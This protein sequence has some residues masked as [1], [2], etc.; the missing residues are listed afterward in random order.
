MSE[1]TELLRSKKG[2]DNS[3]NAGDSI[4]A[5]DWST[6]QQHLPLVAY[7]QSL[8]RM[9]REHPAFRMTTAE[10]ISRYL[11]FE[12]APPGCIAY[13]LNGA[14]VGDSWKSIYVAFNGTGSPQ[15]LTLPP[16]DWKAGNGTVTVGAYSAM[17]L[18]TDPGNRRPTISELISFVR[19]IL[20]RWPRHRRR[21]GRRHTA[22]GC[23]C[24]P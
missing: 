10:Q 7:L 19:Y 20:L 15:T 12:T 6:K 24:R 23:H 2:I 22:K 21:T 16:G 5:I 4:N 13:S 17:I 18:N 9:R 1:G 11:H 14:A 3:Y 8:I